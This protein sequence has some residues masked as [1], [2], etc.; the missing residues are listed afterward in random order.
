MPLC[1]PSQSSEFSAVCSLSITGSE[2]ASVVAGGVFSSVLRNLYCYMPLKGGKKMGLI[3]CIFNDGLK[4]L[5]SKLWKFKKKEPGTVGYFNPEVKQ[6]ISLVLSLKEY[7]F[8][9]Q[10]S[11][12]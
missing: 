5:L 10:Y 11:L 2:V 8:K 3:H 7:Q 9:D 1:V 4:L 12:P 6:G